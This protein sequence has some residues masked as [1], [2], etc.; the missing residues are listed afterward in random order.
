MEKTGGAPQ[1]VASVLR[2]LER[3]GL[4][5]QVPDTDPPIWRRPLT[6]VPEAQT[7]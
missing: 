1:A 2:N 3:H 5:E 4:V 6:A 7:A